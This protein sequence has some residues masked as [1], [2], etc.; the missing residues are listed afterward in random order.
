V[1][2]RTYFVEFDVDYLLLH[3]VVMLR[4]MFGHDFG[5]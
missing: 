4:S 2:Y 5:D 3:G 1:K